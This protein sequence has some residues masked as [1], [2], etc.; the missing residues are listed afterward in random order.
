[1]EGFLRR[2]PSIRTIHGKKIESARLTNANTKAIQDFF[3][4]LDEPTIRAIPPQHRYNMDESGIMEGLG[5]NGLVVGASELRQAYIKESKRGCWM[6]FVE[7]ISAQGHAL[8][9]LVILNGKSIQQQWF[10]ESLAFTTRNWSFTHSQRG[11]I[12]NDSALEW[13]RKIFI[14]ETKPQNPQQRRLLIL[15]GHGSHTTE[16][17]M[18]ECFNHRIHLLYL[19]A[20][21]SHVLQPLDLAIFG[22]LKAAYRKWARQLYI[23]TDTSC[24]GKSGFLICLQKARA[25]AIT[26]QNIKAGWRAGGLWPLNPQKPLRS[27]QLLPQ[28]SPQQTQQQTQQQVNQ[29]FH[30]PKK[31]N[32]IR[33]LMKRLHKSPQSPSFRLATRKLTKAYDQFIL[34]KS[35][36]DAESK[37]LKAQLHLL[38]PRKKGIVKPNPNE[39]FVNIEQI[40]EA[41]RKAKEKEE[42]ERRRAEAWQRDH[43]P[44]RAM[45]QH[46]FEEM[47]YEWQL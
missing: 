15:D 30:T 8:N 25:E 7:C 1:M 11:W 37:S 41:K 12:S 42:L 33:V 43:S 14:P 39:K 20:H 21:T 40:M 27:S 46:S 6:T 5:I 3:R 44:D 2:N 9:P 18:W 47:C 38:Q 34:E 26:S 28:R 29:L 19:P 45:N 23:P 22:P 32:D 13:L 24:H 4:H 35:M 31:S 36:W 10:P 17:F 16:D